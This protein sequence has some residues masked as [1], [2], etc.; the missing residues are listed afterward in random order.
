MPPSVGKPKAIFLLFTAALLL[1]IAACTAS[2]PGD[3]RTAV[4]SAQATA[5]VLQSTPC[6]G[7]DCPNLGITQSG[8]VG[9]FNLSAQGIL[10]IEKFF[11]PKESTENGRWTIDTGTPSPN[12]QWIA[13]TTIGSET[14][15]PVL[16][17]NRG[18]GEWTNLIDALN[19][20]LP[21][22][23]PAYLPEAWW[24]VIGW[25][26]GS[27]RLMIGP[28]DLSL[29]L[30]V[31]LANLTARP[32]T[33]PGGGRGG[34][35]FVSLSPDG[36]AFSYVGED[37]QGSQVLNTLN[38]STGHTTTLLKQPY[39]E[40]VLYNPRYAPNQQQ[41]AF[42]LQKG[43]PDTGLTYAIH[44]LDPANNQVRVIVDG[45]LGLPIPTWSPDSR[46]IAFT[47]NDGSK[48]YTVLPDAAPAPQAS[49]V[50]VVSLADGKQ[51][52]VT[53]TKGQARS[54]QWAKDNQTIAFVPEDGQVQITSIAQPGTTRQL[55]G[56]SLSPE[57]T[58]IFFLP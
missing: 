25:F 57:L 22:D 44:L 46:F 38:L 3:P 27:A 39:A 1:S 5:A 4:P 58:S 21:K 52:Q 34:R 15:G 48:P 8:K 18:T 29:V 53:F 56:P 13:Y 16:L 32:L 37:A 31:D 14:G 41:I 26:P 55:A 36:S 43:R 19:A 45:N 49:N 2:K 7:A 6:T 20:R 50:W 42:L 51:T 40:G 23:Q 9:A 35:L 47:R 54:P 30:I 17:L 24:D 28:T 33:F 11:D 10:P 12:G